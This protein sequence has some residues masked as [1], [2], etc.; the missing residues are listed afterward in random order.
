[1]SGCDL[2]DNSTLLMYTKA[3]LYSFLLHFCS[4]YQG[5]LNNPAN[6]AISDWN[7]FKRT[8]LKI[9]KRKIKE[10]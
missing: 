9:S 5:A 7:G 8:L 4:Q 10:H 3:S 6:Y 1:M 2:Q